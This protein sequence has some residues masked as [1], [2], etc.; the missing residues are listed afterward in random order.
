M[1]A[2]CLRITNAVPRGGYRTRSTIII[3]ET[4]KKRC[5]RGA[6]RI[7]VASR[8]IKARVR[9]TP[10]G[11]IKRVGNTLGNGCCPRADGCIAT[12]RYLLASGAEHRTDKCRT[13]IIRTR[14][15]IS[16]RSPRG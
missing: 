10:I 12:R 7:S 11:G 9:T 13:P 5:G 1:K 4:I 3:T 8:V 15:E 16:G 14:A 6:K 2:G